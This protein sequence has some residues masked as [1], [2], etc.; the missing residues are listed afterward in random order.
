MDEIKQITM[1]DTTNHTNCSVAKLSV[2]IVLIR[3]G[4]VTS[5]TVHEVNGPSSVRVFTVPKQRL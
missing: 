4:Y 1:N 5:S 3:Y 2:D